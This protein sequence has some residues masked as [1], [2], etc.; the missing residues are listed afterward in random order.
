MTAMNT[1]GRETQFAPAARV[2][3]ISAPA[4]L[5]RAAT[6]NNC[7]HDAPLPVDAP[8]AGSRSLRSNVRLGQLGEAHRIWGHRVHYVAQEP[9]SALAVDVAERLGL[10]IP[11]S[12]L[13]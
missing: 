4:R 6:L 9:P 5:E 3:R 7:G 1:N 10:P 13:T 8:W 2:S 12:W 11:G